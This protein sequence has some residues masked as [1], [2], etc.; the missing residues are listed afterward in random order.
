MNCYLSIVY[1]ER[2]TTIHNI[3]IY[4]IIYRHRQ[5]SVAMIGFRGAGE[6]G[7]LTHIF[8]Q[9]YVGHKYIFILKNMYNN[10]PFKIVQ[11]TL[12]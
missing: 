6:G 11:L 10:S 4:Y 2:H 3:L 12:E 9:H 8:S 1:N 7:Q 5:I